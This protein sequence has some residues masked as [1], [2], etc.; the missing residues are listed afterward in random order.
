MTVVTVDTSFQNV[1][2]GLTE[3]AELRDQQGQVIGF[4]TPQK[5]AEDEMFADV[6]ASFDLEEADRRF[7]VFQT[8]GEAGISS[9]VLEVEMDALARGE[10]CSE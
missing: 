8:S 9:E 6:I 10:P 4:F 2:N 1:L 3:K 7:K 5:I